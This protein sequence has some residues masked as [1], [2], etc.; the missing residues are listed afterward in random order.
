MS[1]KQRRNGREYYYRSR[2]SGGKVISE[3][4]GSGV[5]AEFAEQQAGIEQ[6]QRAA[7]RQAWQEVKR[8]E[9]SI[10]R[11]IDDIG[12]QLQALVEAVLLVSGFHKHRR[13]WRKTRG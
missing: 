4:V 10:D 8:S 13:Q 7:Q 11:Q 6:A 2:R 5:Y 12:V 9:E 1:W 3:Y